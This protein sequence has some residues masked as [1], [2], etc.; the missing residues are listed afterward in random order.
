[1][2]VFLGEIMVRKEGLDEKITTIQVVDGNVRCPVIGAIVPLIGNCLNPSK[3]GILETFKCE[4]Y[5]HFVR[6]V[7][8]CG[9]DF[10]S[11]AIEVFCSYPSKLDP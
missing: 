1:M 4:E 5:C 8:D 2:S 9:D 10:E 7:S 6:R 3:D 11:Q